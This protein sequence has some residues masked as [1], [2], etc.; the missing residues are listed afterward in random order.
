MRELLTTHGAGRWLAFF[1]GWVA[2]GRVGLADLAAGVGISA[3]AACASLA[4]IPAAGVR[5][6]PAGVLSYLARFGAGSL[7]AGWDVARRVA[8]TPPRV[9]PGIITLACPVPEGLPRDAFRALASLQPGTLPLAGS[10]AG[11]TVHCLDVNAPVAAAL[12]AEAEA[13]LAMYAHFDGTCGPH[14]PGAGGGRPHG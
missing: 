3:I 4:L 11:L 10:G 13:F 1:A 7:L 6:R 12:D 8:A 14:A 9:A 2:L 5:L